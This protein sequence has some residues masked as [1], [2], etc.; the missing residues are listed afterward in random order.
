VGLLFL[1]TIIL[2][3]QPQAGL[4]AGLNISQISGMVGSSRMSMHMGAYINFPLKGNLQLVPELIYSC[5][6]QHYNPG[7]EDERTLKLGYVQMPITFRYII[8]TKTQTWIETGPQIG[9][10]VHAMDNGT[11]D[12]ADV[13][14][15]LSNTVFA[16][17]AGMGI[18]VN[19]QLSI[20]GRYSF[21]LTDITLYGMIN[22]HNNVAQIGF[23]LRLQ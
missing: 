1:Q 11:T 7:E 18:P 16:W 10:L 6:G 12:K 22:A 5:E 23:S 9:V 19:R 8:G 21:G 4:K 3:A 20:Y 17:N 2:H 13:K 15:S 14:R